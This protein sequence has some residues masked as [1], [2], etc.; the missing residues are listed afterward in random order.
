V[1]ARTTPGDTSMVSTQL[2]PPIAGHGEGPWWDHRLARF[3]WLDM[4]TGIIYATSIE[5]DTHVWQTGRPVVSLARPRRASGYVVADA[6]D[7][8]TTAGFGAPLNHVASVETRRR[9]RLNEGCCAPDGSL[10]IGSMHDD[11]ERGAGSLYR[12]DG[13]G[14][15]TTLI[16][17]VSVSNGLAFLPGGHQAVYAD[18]VE[19][20]I[21]LLEFATESEGLARRPWIAVD[22]ANGQIDGICCDLAGGVWAAVW[23]GGE[24]RHFA[25]DGR[26][27]HRVALP[28]SRPTG[29]ALGGPRG[30]LL[31]VTTSRVP[32]EKTS[33]AAFV[34][35]DVAGRAAPVW[36]FEG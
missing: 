21:D 29:C 12:V 20:S 10:W 18:S 30:D 32:G 35:A 4:M 9:T 15:V 1:Q 3:V 8:Y 25:P 6:G 5:G 24:V 11:L 36:P 34:I 22:R 27:V 13:N 19:D 28:V 14:R 17:L 31:F 23:E 16:D 33:G 2:T 7:V 26:L